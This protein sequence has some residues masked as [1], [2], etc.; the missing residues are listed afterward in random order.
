MTPENKQLF[1]NHL[2][3]AYIEFMNKV[4]KIPGSPMQK[5]QGFFRFDEGHMWMQNA[6]LSFEAPQQP[7]AQNA[8]SV[9]GEAV[10]AIEQPVEQPASN[11]ECAPDAA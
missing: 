8:E 7:E 11:S 2:R 9:E 10:E 5:Q 6:I 1:V 3:E 4:L